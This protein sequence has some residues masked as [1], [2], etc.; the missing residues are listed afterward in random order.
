MVCP[1]VPIEVIHETTPKLYSYK[2]KLLLYK[3]SF[4]EHKDAR[5]HEH[6]IVLFLKRLENRKREQK[7]FLKLISS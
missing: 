1:G 5:W 2:E 4:V 3:A 6:H 7:S